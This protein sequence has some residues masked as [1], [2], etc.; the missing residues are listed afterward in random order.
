MPQQRSTEPRLFKVDQRQPMTDGEIIAPCRIQ[1]F[2][3]QMRP[4]TAV[5]VSQILAL[6]ND[7]VE[8]KTA[9]EQITRAET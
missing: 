6:L 5:T 4:M 1:E 3:W 8:I 2:G 7:F 9:S